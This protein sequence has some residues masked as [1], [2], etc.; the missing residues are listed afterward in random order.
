MLAILSAGALQPQQFVGLGLGMAW[1]LR[2]G[3]LNCA[4]YTQL[5]SL[6]LG[7]VNFFVV[8]VAITGLGRERCRACSARASSSCH[9]LLVRLHA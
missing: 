7:C 1:R 9:V 3:S 8:F 2:V 6:P 4:T 5:R